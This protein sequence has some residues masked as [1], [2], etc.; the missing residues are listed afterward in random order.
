MA[1]N[2]YMTIR[3]VYVAHHKFFVPRLNVLRSLL[4]FDAL[5]SQGMSVMC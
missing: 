3:M 4:C 5:V 2:V 1:E